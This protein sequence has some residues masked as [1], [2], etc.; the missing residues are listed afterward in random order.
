[1]RENKLTKTRN[2]LLSAL[3]AVTLAGTSVLPALAEDTTSTT[4]PTVIN[5][6]T[7]SKEYKLSSPTDDT[8]TDASTIYAS[9]EETFKFS[10]GNSYA[11]STTEGKASLAA[12][13]GTS[14]NINTKDVEDI[15]GLDPAVKESTNI[16]QTIDVDFVKFKAGTATS[17]GAK[18]DVTIRATGTY[19]KPG[20]YYYDFHEVDGATAG[21]TYSTI[22]Y[23][24]A[25]TVE[26]INGTYG[27][28]AIKLINK[29]TGNKVDTISNIYGA[30]KLTFT[31]KVAGNMGDTKKEF[32]VTLTLTAPT[33]TT[34][35]STINVAGASEITSISPEDWKNGSYSQTFKVKDATTISLT[36]IPAGVKWL[37]KE[38]NYSDAGYSTQYTMPDGSTATNETLKNIT[39][40]MNAE[41]T[42]TVTITNTRNTTIDTGIFTSNAPYFMILGIAVIGGIVYFAANKKRHA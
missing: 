13:K 15:S 24:A 3:A 22:N 26:N 8:S 9:P 2:I 38:D 6:A 39:N 4:T 42:S 10:S 25:V 7:F 21:V 1:M 23:R 41:Q 29:T 27:V 18:A 28:T 40:T 16:P 31:K 34:V 12:L 33:G 20:I 17:G 14:W 19:T 32:N 35:R 37:V 5:T 30:G 11:A 36:N